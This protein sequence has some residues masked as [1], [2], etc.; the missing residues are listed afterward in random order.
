MRVTAN[1][2]IQ[3]GTVQ[4]NGLIPV[5]FTNPLQI[6][7]TDLEGRKKTQRRSQSQNGVAGPNVQGQLKTRSAI[8]PQLIFMN[9]ANRKA[10]VL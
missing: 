3:R 10:T 6:R 2:R 7:T 4:G 9:W 5:D 1:P 8:E